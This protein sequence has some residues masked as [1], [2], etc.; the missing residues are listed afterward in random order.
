MSLTAGIVG[1]GTSPRGVLKELRVMDWIGLD[2]LR[3]KGK[4]FSP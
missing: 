4:I 3:K 1:K 2:G